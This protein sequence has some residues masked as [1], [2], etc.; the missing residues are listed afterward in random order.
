MTT[1]PVLAMAQYTSDE[2]S[3]KSNMISPDIFWESVLDAGAGV[4]NHR[5]KLADT[6]DTLIVDG[7]RFKFTSVEDERG[8]GVFV[9]RLERT[10][11]EQ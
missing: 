10:D 2:I 7:V 1:Y 6:N 8:R 9:H 4:I 5:E 3:Q 11:A